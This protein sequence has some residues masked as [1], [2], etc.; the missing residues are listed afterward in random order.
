MAWNQHIHKTVLIF[1]HVFFFADYIPYNEQIGIRSVSAQFGQDPCCCCCPC[2]PPMPM[3]QPPMPM[4][5][6]P[7]PPMQMMPP[8]P[9]IICCCPPPMPPPPPPIQQM[10]PP[11]GQMGPPPCC[12]CP[13]PPSM[14]GQQQQM[15]PP[16]CPPCP[17]PQQQPQFGPQQQF[18]P[19]PCNCPPICIRLSFG[20]GFAP[21]GSGPQPG[22]QPVQQPPQYQ[23]PPTPQFGSQLPPQ[24]QQQ[25]CCCTCTCQPQAGFGQKKRRR[26]RRRQAQF[27]PTFFDT[28]FT[29]PPMPNA[30][31]SF[32]EP[33]PFG[34]MPKHIYFPP[35]NT[36]SQPCTCSCPCESQPIERPQ[37]VFNQNGEMFS[38]VVPPPF[39]Q[40]PA[41]FWQQF[42][43]SNGK[44]SPNFGG[45]NSIHPTFDAPQM[46]APKAVMNGNI[47]TL[48]ELFMN[49]KDYALEK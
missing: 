16:P 12:C 20:D 44:A 4:C 32:E 47:K 21:A 46:S 40:L 34:P 25:C 2:P 36:N 29:Q 49:P 43:T 18:G 31:P 33:L 8:P 24:G 26:R 27:F 10:M 45:E 22:P 23:P 15:G 39:D 14:F 11:M 1:L 30:Q 41:T 17:P 7:P 48:S 37:S 35:A 6:C 9:P 3:Q 19:P 28:S 42:F 5:C 38:Q 13:Q